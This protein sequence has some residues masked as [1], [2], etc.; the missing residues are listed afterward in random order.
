MKI[1]NEHHRVIFKEKQGG[2]D[3]ESEPFFFPAGTAGT[4]IAV[5]LS[6]GMYTVEVTRN[7]DT[8]VILDVPQIAV[9]CE[10]HWEE[11]GLKQRKCFQC[12]GKELFGNSGWETV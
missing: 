4:I 6:F 11:A 10:H 3:G 2:L 8:P 5:H 1:L 12:G 9:D 7:G